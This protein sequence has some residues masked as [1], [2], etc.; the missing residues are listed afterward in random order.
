VQLGAE[1]C[2]FFSVFVLV[3]IVMRVSAGREMA[4]F[5]ATF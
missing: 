4:T 2:G 1:L 5:L 3:C